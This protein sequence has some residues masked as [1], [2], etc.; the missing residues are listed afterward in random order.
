MTRT[1]TADPV[2]DHRAHLGEGPVWDA[3][4]QR[5]LY[6]DIEGGAVLA[7]DPAA[8][9][10]KVLFHH[11]DYVTAV[12]P[13]RDGRLLLGL[14]DGLGVWDERAPDRPPTLVVPLQADD[15]RLRCNDATVAPDGAVW[16]G[17]MHLDDGEGAARLYRVA[18]DGAPRPQRGGLTI[19]NGLGFSPDGRVLYHADTPTGRVDAL[20]LAADRHSI[21]DVRPFVSPPDAAGQPDGLTVDADGGVWVAL[22]SGGTVCRFTA[23]GG[24]DAMVE[25]PA[26]HTTSCAFG[27][28]DLDTL[29]ITTGG[30]EVGGRGDAAGALFRAEVGVTGLPANLATVE[31]P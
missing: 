5:L 17:T 15:D 18:D 8:G 3:D 12:L 19:S 7:H 30:P 9:A 4:R 31:V 16:I 11:D 6:V 20:L 21:D 14:R 24:L 23:D 26:S 10:T 25:V 13:H 28:P 22:W 29:F 2:G 1:L 27:G